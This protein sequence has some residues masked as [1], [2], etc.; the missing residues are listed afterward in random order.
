MAVAEQFTVR[1]PREIIVGWGAIGELGKLTAGL[2]KRPMLVVGGGSLRKSGRLEGI[3]RELEALG[4]H[5]TVFE[6][7]EHDPSTETIDRGREEFLAASCD[8]LVAIGGGSAMDAGKAIAGLSGETAPT[9]EFVRGKHITAPVPP[10]IACTTTS[11]TGSEVTHVSVLTDK[12]RSVKASI[13]TAGMMPSVAIVDA[14]LTVSMPREQTAYSGLDAFTQ[15][16]ESYVSVGANPFSDP[17]ALEAAVR[18]ARWLRTAYERGTHQEARE[19]MATGSMLAGLALASA[20]LGLVHGIAHP[21]GALYGLA[22][23]EACALLLPYVMEYNA[24]A[25]RGKFAHLARAMRLVSFSEE[26]EGAASCLVAWTRELCGVLGCL[27]P[28]S[29][30]GLSRADYPAIVEA[31]MAS[32][33]SKANPRRVNPEDV[34]ELLDRA[35]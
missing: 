29:Q 31:T 33:S 30:F 13:R 2:G 18:I 8:C 4:L 24:E 25:A 16:V 26:D 20:R 6:G 1:S 21:L 23:G 5:V 10:I 12:E 32:G 19:N 7:I 28:F 14:E 34:V 3:V 22:H 15:A 9:A 17:L 27:R 35:M 11:G